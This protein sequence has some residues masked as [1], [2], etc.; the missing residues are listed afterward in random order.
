MAGGNVFITFSHNMNITIKQSV[1]FKLLP[2]KWC[3]EILMRRVRMWCNIY[4]SSIVTIIDTS[5]IIH[6]IYPSNF[7]DMMR[8]SSFIFYMCML[9]TNRQET[10]TWR[11]LKN[12]E[13]KKKNICKLLSMNTHCIKKKV[14]CKSPLVLYISFISQNTYQPLSRLVLVF[15]T[16]MTT[17][18]ITNKWTNHKRSQ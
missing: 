13:M 2:E 16:N 18:N 6:F 14:C 5:N 7:F 1:Y 17:T 8:L 15:A 10:K 12:N 9:Q 11:T 4:L 3:T